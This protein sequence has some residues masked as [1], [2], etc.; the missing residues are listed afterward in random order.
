MKKYIAAVAASI[1]LTACGGGSDS[2]GLFSLWTNNTTGATIDLQSAQFGTQNVISLYPPTA[3]KCLC[4]L[5][6]IGDESS[7]SYALT[8]CIVSPYDSATDG[9]CKAL[10]S[11]GNYTNAE[12]TLTLSNSAGSTTYR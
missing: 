3:V 8:S 9:Q 4:R 6:I 12:N 1:V 7:G 2:K 10:N 11:T 5:A